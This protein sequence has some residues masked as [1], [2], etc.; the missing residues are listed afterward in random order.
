MK[1]S[2]AAFYS[3]GAAS[4][5]SGVLVSFLPLY[6]FGITRSDFLAASIA[7]VPSVTAIATSPLWGGLKDRSENSMPLML[8]GVLPYAAVSFSWSSLAT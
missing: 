4:V 2:T 8:V 7:A 1:G 3:L 5:T 6:V